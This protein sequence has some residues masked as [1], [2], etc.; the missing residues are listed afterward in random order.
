MESF[1]NRVNHKMQKYKNSINDIKKIS[2]Q[3]ISEYDKRLET[4]Q[5]EMVEIIMKNTNF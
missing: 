4:M 2:S 5:R 1:N 3:K